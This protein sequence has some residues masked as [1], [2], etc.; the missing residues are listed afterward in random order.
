MKIAEQIIEFI[1]SVAKNAILVGIIGGL[2][3]FALLVFAILMPEQV[4]DA[5]QILGSLFGA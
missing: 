5:F 3:L 2:M 4:I 1:F